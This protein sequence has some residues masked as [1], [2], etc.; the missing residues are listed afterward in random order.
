MDVA[1]FSVNS[2]ISVFKVMPRP[3]T[4][5]KNLVYMEVI[6]GA[7]FI[8]EQAPRLKKLIQIYRPKE[9]VIDSNGLGS[10]LMDAMTISSTDAK[11]GEIFP[12]YYAF[13]DE[14]YLPPSCRNAREEPMPEQNAIIYSLKANGTNNG[15]IH[16]NAFAQIMNGSV[17][18]L[19]SE[20]V[21]K[22]RLMATKKGQKMDHYSRRE[23]LLPYEMTSRLIDEMNNLRL[24]PT[25]TQNKMD[26]EQISKSIPKDRWSSLEYGLWRIKYYEDKANRKAKN[27]GDGNKFAF[28]TP[29]TRR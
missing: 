25:G 23:F 1:R 9:V 8:T 4:F 22:D 12:P 27:R 24:K 13:N 7:N 3:E 29:R 10:G 15:F 19:A 26:I 2:V 16:A 17:S 21:A 14:D 11:T 18:F 5:K 6:H 28:F 20:Q